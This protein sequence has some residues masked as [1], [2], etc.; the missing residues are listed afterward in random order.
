M[1]RKSLQLTVRSLRGIPR[2]T[3][4]ESCLSVQM[5]KYSRYAQRRPAAIVNE[6]DLFDVEVKNTT[7]PKVQR[8]PR[9]Q[10]KN[11]LSETKKENIKILREVEARNIERENMQILREVK[12]ST[13][14]DKVE[15]HEESKNKE[16]EKESSPKNVYT[17][18]KENEKLVS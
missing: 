13:K 6:D 2:V 14:T 3:S 1:L 16:N 10:S 15:S 4:N 9:S 17:K 18:L 7:P 12:A 11:R 5:Q 8:K